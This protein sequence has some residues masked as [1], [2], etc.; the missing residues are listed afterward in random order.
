MAELKVHGKRQTQDIL[1]PVI[2]RKIQRQQLF[3]EESTKKLEAENTHSLYNKGSGVQSQK[4][5][6]WLQAFCICLIFIKKYIK[7]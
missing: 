6:D 3:S 7:V 1:T 2:F 5:R 4:L